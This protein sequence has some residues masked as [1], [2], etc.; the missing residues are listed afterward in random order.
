MRIVKQAFDTF[1][2]LYTDFSFAYSKNIIKLLEKLEEQYRRTRAGQELLRT[3]KN[4][5]HSISY[6]I[7]KEENI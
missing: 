3:L 6:F 1:S 5:P 2:P 7:E 4:I